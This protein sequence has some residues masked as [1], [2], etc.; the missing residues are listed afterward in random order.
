MANDAVAWS[1]SRSGDSCGA[2]NTPPN[3]DSALA[4]RSLRALHAVLASAD[5]ARREAE[6]DNAR[7][8]AALLAAREQLAHA[9]QIVFAAPRDSLVVQP[10]VGSSAS[11][12]AALP[13]ASPL[14]TEPL[15]APVGATTWVAAFDA[16][17]D[18]ENNVAVST[19]LRR[20]AAAM[21]VSAAALFP[22]KT[23][24]VSVAQHR[25]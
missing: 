12:V 6:A 11:C 4:E 7:L 9:P 22:Q 18:K 20:C 23:A 10:L 2:G 19:E 21:G 25:A 14:Q 8:R 1:L 17:A 5:A 13:P 15:I 16:V 24:G 3:V